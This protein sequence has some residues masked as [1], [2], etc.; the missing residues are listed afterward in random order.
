MSNDEFLHYGVKGMRWGVRKRR[1]SG[2]SSTGSQNGTKQAIKD[3]GGPPRSGGGTTNVQKSGRFMTDKELQSA[4]NRIKLEQEYAR[5]TAVPPSKGKQIVTKALETGGQQVANKLVQSTFEYALGRAGV[6][7]FGSGG[8]PLKKPKKEADD[9]P[10]APAPP[11]DVAKPKP[12]SEKK[13]KVEVFE[14]KKEEPAKGKELDL[15]NQVDSTAR[16]VP[17]KFT[18]RKP[19]PRRPRP[20]KQQRP[21]PKYN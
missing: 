10:D 20:S 3:G 5:L 21:R 1:D 8:G 11:K 9:T 13:P 4:I 19:Q 17:P 6:P 14:P 18:Q 15:P 7:G 16:D 2:S 12:K